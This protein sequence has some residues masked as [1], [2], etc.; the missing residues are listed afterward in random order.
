MGKGEAVD[1]DVR[2]FLGN[3]REQIVGEWTTAVG[4]LRPTDGKRPLLAN[5]V[6]EL[7][8]R[9]ADLAQQVVN[10]ESVERTFAIAREQTPVPPE[11]SFDVA[12]LLLEFSALRACV[13]RAWQHA[14]AAAGDGEG[15]RALDVA[16]DALMTALVSA[17]HDA[18]RAQIAK[19]TAEREGPLGK[20][21]SL[22]AA[23]PVGIAF[24][25]RNLRYLRINDALAALNG[26]PASEHIGR[27]IVEMLP[28]VPLLEPML[29]D[30]MESGTAVLNREFTRRSP[31]GKPGTYLATFFPVRGRSG[32][33]VG[34]GGLVSDITENRRAEKD[35]RLVQERMQAILEHAPALIWVKDHQGHIVLANHR[36]AEAL[37]HPY[38]QVVGR[39]S[40]ELLPADVAAQHQSHD[41]QVMQQRHALEAE[42]IM[43]GPGGT[44]TFLS[45]KFP[46]PGNPPMVGGI[47]TEISDRKRIEQE[48]RVAVQAR[49]RVL[50]A[51]SHDLRNPLNTIQVTSA[52]LLAQL[53][54]DQRWRRHLEI[55]HRSCLR[56]DHLI[57]DLLDMASIGAGRLS[58]ETRPESADAII[59]EAIE[60][61]EPLADERKV[62]LVRGGCA[63]DTLVDCDRHRV[64]QVFANLIG[65][66]LKFCRAGDTVTIGCE[67]AEAAVGFWVEDTGPGISPE[68][69][70]RLFDPYWSGP[71]TKTGVGLGLYIARGIVERHG[72]E[73]DVE[74]RLG[75]GERFSF[76]IPTASRQ[77]RGDRSPNP[78]P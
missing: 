1:F 44:R 18:A 50:A 63:D 29:R 8:G 78:E 20:L 33:I 7:L 43:P 54:G 31:S 60:L 28:D 32:E 2:S 69:L 12:P 72:G 40:D 58:L 9:I 67:R 65:N 77:P 53:A 27:S 48:L 14:P 5:Y 34:V 42:E 74:S 64:M 26:C 35:L 36:L 16:I 49:D 17:S 11:E 15:R 57:T 56:M 45:S 76:T 46:L 3:S 39:R 4:E 47:A 66:A 55:I 24:L 75:R 13:V 71:E 25:D 23:S 59:R 21:E 73:I 22:L 61:H 30:V 70:P 62:S 37:G 52:T 51:V 41:R 10:G 6:H 19:L 38:E 68:L